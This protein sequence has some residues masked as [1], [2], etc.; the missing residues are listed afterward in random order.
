[1]RPPSATPAALS[2]YVVLEL[3]PAAPPAI[4]ATLSTSR[5][6]P[7]PGTEPSSFARPASAATPV[8]VPIVS[9]KSVSMIAKIVRSAVSRPRLNTLPRSNF[10]R[11]LKVLL[12]GV[13]TKSVG[14]LATPVTNASTVVA[15]M[16]M[17]RAPRIFSTQRAIVRAR[18]AQKTNCAGS[19]G[20]T[21]ATGGTPPCGETMAPPFTNPMNRM[22]RPMPTPI[23]RLRA[24][25]TAF[26]IASRRPISTRTV[27]AMP[28]R[29]I[30][31]M[32]PGRVRPLPRTRVKA[33]T[34]LIPSPAASASG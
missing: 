24:S 17:I 3:M 12:V 13:M 4:A 29:T 19:V 18:P 23:A 1:M 2:M 21:G 16:L 30:T 32:A 10:P 15:R 6:R 26:M 22:K 14:T 9:K 8:T 34:A 33:T 5:T 11:V 7:I 27:T 25:G 31:P 20:N 28:S